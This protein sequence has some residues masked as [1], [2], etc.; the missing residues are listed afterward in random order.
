MLLVL[1][2]IFKAVACQSAGVEK[3][4][5]VRCS[6]ALGMEIWTNRKISCQRAGADPGIFNG[7]GGGRGWCQTATK[8]PGGPSIKIGI[9]LSIEKSIKIGK[10]D[11]IVID[12]MGQSIEIDDTLVSFT[13]SSRF[14]RFHRFI[15]E[16]ASVLLFIQKW[17]LISC[18]QWIYRQL[19]CNWASKD[20]T[21]ITLKK[22]FFC[23]A[24]ID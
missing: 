4:G 24:D 23:L 15:S 20:Q 10:S 14:Y 19:S 17:T 22:V 16:N 11:L 6:W 5:L 8:L 12:C 21:I 18:K 9:D 3:N 7:G 13:D 1:L 2:H